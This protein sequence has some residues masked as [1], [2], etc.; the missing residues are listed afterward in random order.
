MGLIEEARRM[1][2]PGRRPSELPP[3]PDIHIPKLGRKYVYDYMLS[4][5]GSISRS[6][7]SHLA[8]QLYDDARLD[9]VQ[10]LAASGVAAGIL[11]IKDVRGD[12]F[13]NRVALSYEREEM[14]RPDEDFT[15]P[16]KPTQQP[17]SLIDAIA[18]GGPARPLIRSF[19]SLE[20]LGLAN[21][22]KVDGEELF[23]PTNRGR[24]HAQGLG[25]IFDY[26][27]WQGRND[28]VVAVGRRGKTQILPVTPQ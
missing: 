3:T 1:F 20:S 14:E 4:K 25:F 21:V 8:E 18:G 24:A 22:Q 13:L 19:Y 12:S 17:R 28:L 6:G 26:I 10:S 15:I 27:D 2:T 7:I 16:R 11:S 9:R 5:A 23:V